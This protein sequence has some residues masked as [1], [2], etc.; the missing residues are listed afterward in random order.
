MGL[1]DDCVVL[2]V[3]MLN[4]HVRHWEIWKT[5]QN[6]REEKRQILGIFWYIS[7]KFYFSL[8]QLDNHGYNCLYYCD[9]ANICIFNELLKSVPNYQWIPGSTCSP[10]LPLTKKAVKFNKSSQKSCKDCVHSCLS[11]WNYL[12]FRPKNGALC[13]TGPNPPEIIIVSLTTFRECVWKWVMELMTYITESSPCLLWMFWTSTRACSASPSTVHIS[14]LF[15]HLLSLLLFSAALAIWGTNGVHGEV[16]LYN[17]VAKVT[18][19]INLFKILC[20][21]KVVCLVYDTWT[22]GL[23]HHLLIHTHLCLTSV[24]V[25]TISLRQCTWGKYELYRHHKF[26]KVMK[27][28]GTDHYKFWH[29]HAFVNN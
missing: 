23:K 17:T 29:S 8:W 7:C 19:A 22:F 5:E 12:F 4:V 15:T 2:T 20:I 26:G 9:Y 28:T 10:C 1:R 25:E 6:P 18:L 13:N 16:K 27:G 14:T 3:P 24:I 21:E 11:N